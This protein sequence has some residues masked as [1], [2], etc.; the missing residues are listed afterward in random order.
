MFREEVAAHAAGEQPAGGGDSVHHAGFEVFVLWGEEDIYLFFILLKHK[1]YFIF[2]VY[3]VVQNCSSCGEKNWDFGKEK[4]A[5]G[6][7]QTFISFQK[8]KTRKI[9][10]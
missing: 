2:F 1:F 6:K 4:I 9:L 5:L 7:S 8:E 3:S 10:F